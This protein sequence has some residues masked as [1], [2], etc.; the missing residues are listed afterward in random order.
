MPA[1]ALRKQSALAP[2]QPA[3][4]RSEV[5]ARYRSFREMSRRHHS[6][7]LDFLSKSAILQQGR[8]LGLARGKTFAL[9][10]VDD[11]NLAFDLTIYTSP[12]GR[13]RA[14][15]RYARAAQCAP[16]SEEA[17]VLEAMRDAHFAIFA[18]QRQHPTAGLILKDL[19]GDVE[20]W[21]VD[22]GLE[23]SLSI[24]KVFATRYFTPEDFSMTAGII[25]PI[26]KALLMD[27]V[28][29][30]PSLARMA[31]GEAVQDRRFGEAIYRVAL[32]GGIMA[33]VTYLDPSGIGDVT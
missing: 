29:F 13:S 3:P 15:D 18:V 17:L 9:D 31:A 24:G 4:S 2:Q 16:G 6:K 5:L 32:A 28:D 8:R 27:A 26:D 19:F 33:G 12:P 21:L 10:S 7:I 1:A 20:L 22:E 23:T 14:I 25:V 30:A 11:L